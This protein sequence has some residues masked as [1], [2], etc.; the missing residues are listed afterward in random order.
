MRYR[1]Q[2]SGIIE[3]EALHRSPTDEAIAFGALETVGSPQATP[4]ETEG[5][6]PLLPPGPD[7]VLLDLHLPPTHSG[8]VFLRIHTGNSKTRVLVINSEYA[9]ESISMEWGEKRFQKTNDAGMG[10]STPQ[11]LAGGP[12][13]SLEAGEDFDA[14]SPT[15]PFSE[16]DHEILR[17]LVEG[18]RNKQI[19]AHL[20]MAEKTVRNRLIG[21][22]GKLG[23]SSRIE[24]ARL[25]TAAKPLAP[26]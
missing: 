7:A 3:V 9:P 22:F 10:E 24:A 5:V 4:A 13:S 17:R 16:V 15:E 11:R 20:G 6:D 21:I 23:V 26:R 1:I 14:K 25:Y 18:Q 2:K 12:P 19:A 8:D